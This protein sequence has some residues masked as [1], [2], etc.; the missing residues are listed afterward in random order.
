MVSDKLAVLHQGRQV[1]DQQALGSESK[2]GR[3]WGG[4]AMLVVQ[5]V[6]WRGSGQDCGPGLLG[7]RVPRGQG[8]ETRR[9]MGLSS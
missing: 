7:G 1:M 6:G 5:L 2:G 4:V 9:G 3:V 8:G